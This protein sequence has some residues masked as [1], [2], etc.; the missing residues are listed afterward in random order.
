MNKIMHP[1][2]IKFF[3][4]CMDHGK[5]TACFLRTISSEI[6]HNKSFPTNFS[7]NKIVDFISSKK[8]NRRNFRLTNFRR[9]FEGKTLTKF[10]GTHFEL[11]SNRILTKFQR[12]N[13]W[14]HFDGDVE[15]FDEIP[16][17]LSVGNFV[18]YYFLN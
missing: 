7:T 14:W 12:T 15:N 4:N 16:T 6:L 17:I 11:N 9:N 8:K 3:L 5:K 2:N 18:N 13:F 1:W 10:W